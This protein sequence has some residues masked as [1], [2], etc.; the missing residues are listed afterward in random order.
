MD[1][2]RKWKKVRPWQELTGKDQEINLLRKNGLKLEKNSI[3]Q[4]F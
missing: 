3:L 2:M 4:S 1:L